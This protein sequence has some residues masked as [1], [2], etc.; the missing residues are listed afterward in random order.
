MQEIK[1]LEE[2]EET[3]ESFVIGAVDWGLKLIPPPFSGGRFRDRVSSA[4][5]K[6]LVSQRTDQF[7]QSVHG[8]RS[9]EDL[10]RI[11]CICTVSPGRR[12]P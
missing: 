3:V 6:T 11:V 2:Y 9:A 8:P 5:V 10:K 12:L 4:A 7:V 1:L